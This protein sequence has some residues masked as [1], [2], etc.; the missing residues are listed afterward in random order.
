MT[1]FPLDRISSVESGHMR[2]R[3]WLRFCGQESAGSVRYNTR[4]LRAVNRFLHRLCKALL[5]RAYLSPA[6]AMCLG[7]E[8]DI[9]FGN[10]L[11]GELLRGETALIQFFQPP[12]LRKRRR[13][14]LPRWTHFAGDLLVV[15]D[16]RLLWITDCERGFY[17]AYGSIA[18]YAPFHAVR[19]ILFVDSGAAPLVEIQLAGGQRWQIPITREYVRNARDLVDLFHVR[20]APTLES[21]GR[22]RPT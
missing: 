22:A 1:E 11:N 8:L 3:G 10:V 12:E 13:W 15:T 17:S 19:N 14:L 6:P 7:S 21:P 18:S 9:K 16:R 2:L 5:N 20:I 4:G